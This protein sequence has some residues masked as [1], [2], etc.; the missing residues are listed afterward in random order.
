MITG[1]RH[2]HLN[3]FSSQPHRIA[4]PFLF[5]FSLPLISQDDVHAEVARVS[6]SVQNWPLEAA[7]SFFLHFFT[8]IK[9]KTFFFARSESELGLELREGRL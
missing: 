6:R 9:P 1:Q 2:N 4:A 8:F 3:S 5:S 7:L